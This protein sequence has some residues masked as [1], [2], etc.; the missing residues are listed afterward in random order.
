VI[1]VDQPVQKIHEYVDIEIEQ[2]EGNGEELNIHAIINRF[3]R[4]FD[5]PNAPLL[6]TGII[7]LPGNRILLMVDMHHIIMDGISAE[8]LAADFI[9]L[10]NEEELTPLRLQY[11][12]FSEWKLHGKVREAIDKQGTYWLKEFAG[13]I[14]VLN[15]PWDYKR[16]SS[17]SFSGDKFGFKL[18]RETVKPLRMLAS[19]EGCTMFMLI[20]AIYNILLAKICDSEDIIIGTLLSGRNHEDLKKVIGLFVNTLPL[21]NFPKRDIS[22]VEFLKSVKKRTLEAYENQDYQFLD[23]VDKLQLERDITRNPLFDVM[24]F[25]ENEDEKLLEMHKNTDTKLKLKQYN[26]TNNLIS[27]LDLTLTGREVGEDLFFTF[28]Y[29]TKLFEKATIERFFRYFLEIP[30]YVIKKKKN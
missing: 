19:K 13:E 9:S 15:L 6:R 21:R 22:F 29:S 20:L 14:P 17:K 2:Y 8:I 12:D 18:P 25:F 10:Y 5:L 26:Y 11:K 28:E 16:G 3:I 7:N 23:L 1:L 30:G 27:K 4:P 24:F